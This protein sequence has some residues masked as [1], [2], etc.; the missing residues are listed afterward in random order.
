M[1]SHK[2][3]EDKR[4]TNGHMII[5][6]IYKRNPRDCHRLYFDLECFPSSVISSVN[7]ASLAMSRA[8]RPSWRG[9][10]GV[11]NGRV[12]ELIVG[13]GSGFGRLA[14]ICTEIKEGNR[15]MRIHANSN[16]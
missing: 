8:V 2:H 16:L 11:N 6:K 3:K 12:I 13:V 14:D 4:D 7:P 5:D 1:H 10:R 9:D 15:Y